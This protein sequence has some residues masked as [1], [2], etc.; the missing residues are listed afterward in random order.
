MAVKVLSVELESM[1]GE[2]EFISEIVALCDIRHENLVALRG[3]CV[4][5]AKRC[6]V[7]DY[8]ANSSLSKTFLGEEH[9]RMRFTWKLRKDIAIGVARGLAFLHEEIKPYIV[10][11]DIKARNILLDEKLNPK[12]GDFGLA[13]LLRDSKMTH[14]STG[15]AGTFG[16]LAPEYAVSGH[17]T[18]KSDVY[19]FGVLLLEIVSGLAVVGFDLQ[20][21]EQFLVDKV[22]ERYKEENLLLVV[23]PLLINKGDFPV[24]E[25]VR[26]LKIG[27]LCVQ[28]I[29]RLRPS[30][31]SAVKMLINNDIDIGEKEI[32]KPGRIA[33]LM[34]L[35]VGR[36][37]NS[38]YS[39]F[40]G[41]SGTTTSTSSPQLPPVRHPTTSL[42][43][44]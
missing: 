13:K 39:L 6:L 24:E 35:K 36:N 17:L 7:Y 26:F 43:H 33:S 19:S 32:V 27:L 21:E 9:N 4:D 3:C 5:G 29:T 41:E 22:Y 8:M 34:D 18:R 12:V 25:A 10:H 2:R 16:Y 38:S 15:V 31:S 40:S 44:Y 37:K 14:L 11:R 20:F 42:H 28:E 23:D 1:R 30:M